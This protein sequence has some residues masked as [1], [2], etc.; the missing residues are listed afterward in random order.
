MI[1]V[2]CFLIFLA[3]SV[4]GFGLGRDAGPRYESVRALYDRRLKEKRK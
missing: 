1:V 4:F 3:G 2:T